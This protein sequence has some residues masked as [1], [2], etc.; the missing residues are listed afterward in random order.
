MLKGIDMDYQK[1]FTFNLNF[2][3][4]VTVFIC[5]AKSILQDAGQIADH[6]FF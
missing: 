4:R 2:R 5:F 3:I 6:R 1:Q